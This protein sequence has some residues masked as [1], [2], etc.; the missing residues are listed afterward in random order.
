MRGV[1]VPID[2]TAWASLCEVPQVRVA[3]PTYDRPTAPFWTVMP[4]NPCR[5]S[6]SL[7]EASGL[8]PT[9]VSTTSTET[10]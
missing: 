7:T 9:L 6:V 5:F 2:E 3:Y 1:A 10:E 8:P 4:S